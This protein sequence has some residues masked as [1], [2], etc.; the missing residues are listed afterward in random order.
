MNISKEGL[1]LIKEFEGL[2]LKA[3]KAVP[4]EPYYTIGYGHYGR[5]VKEG[6]EITEEQADR[7]L[8]M[9]LASAERAVRSID[10]YKDMS[11][12]QYDAL[13]SFTYNCGA[14][15]LKKL[16]N[17]RSL[18]VIGKKITL[19]NKAG[20][21]VLKGLVRRREAEKKLFFS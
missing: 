2:R 8:K 14:G 21:R 3:Y 13:V 1:N 7:Y 9:D 17:G 19:Y 12:G 16:T 5:D 6:M 18:D 20:G 15:N 10:Q 11:Q 4:S